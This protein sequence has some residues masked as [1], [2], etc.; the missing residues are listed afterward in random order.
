MWLC[1]SRRLRRFKNIHADHE[2]CFIIGNGPSIRQQDLTRLR[3]EI[4]F[5]TNW[6]ILHEHFDRLKINYY[7]ASDPNIWRQRKGFP[8]LLYSV[9]DRNREVVK[10]FEHTAKSVCKSQ[11]LFPGHDVYF[12]R[13]DYSKKVYDGFVSLD[14]SKLVC[15]GTSV[16]IDFCLP[17]AYYMGFRKVYLLGCD[18]DYG[19]AQGA[20]SSPVYFYD[21]NK[22]PHPT[23]SAEVMAKQW[24]T[25]GFKSYRIMRDMFEANGRK[26]YNATLG[27]KLEVF[28]RVDFERVLDAKPENE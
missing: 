15:H 19:L 3:D 20:D 8:E 11:K 5:V 23:V 10:F 25:W 13:L 26:I 18:C 6:F 24:E 4:T 22:Y 17:L 9:L 28:E 14:V 27:G 16:I 2:R 7:C 1:E 21:Y 12:I